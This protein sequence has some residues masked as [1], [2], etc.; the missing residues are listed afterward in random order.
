MPIAAGTRIERYEIVALVGRGAMGE[1]YRARD[2]VLQRSVAIKL[3][4][5]VD[6]RSG[7]RSL[8]EAR[9]ASGLNHPNI[10]TIYE[11][12]QVGDKPFI[13]M[14]HV[15]GKT[16]SSL[17]A[18]EP[19]SLDQTVR[20]GVQIADALAHAHSHG[21]V[22][23]DLKSS[24]IMVG[25]DGRAK[26]LDFGL[27]VRRPEDDEDLTRSDAH[28]L[29]PLAGT[30][31]YLAPELLKGEANDR[32]SDIW[33]LGVVLYTMVSG[34]LPFR[35]QTVFELIAAILHQSPVD[36]PPSVPASLR[37]I[38]SR[39]LSKERSRRYQR[40][41]DVAA[42]L[43]TVGSDA[44]A[45]SLGPIP[46]RTRRPANSLAVMPLTNASHEADAEYLSDGITE[47]IIN[48]LAGL[49]NLRIIPRS[50]V[51]RYKGQHID[52]FALAARGETA[53]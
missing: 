53:N 1:V 43:E 37:L 24:N 23:C 36:L 51:F 16:L 44:T 25:T 4:T 35:G 6:E 9:A 3:L 2:T 49:P 12:N 5:G 42:A 8:Q 32:Q 50:T 14:E 41:S 31:P 30:L 19:C 39:C 20:L 11:V 26:I 29:G 15:D 47:A 52:P 18:V 22:H 34:E 10:C 7:A 46:S 27:A 48:S 38:V 28:L 45:K 40:A 33:A 13:V 21:I 17:I